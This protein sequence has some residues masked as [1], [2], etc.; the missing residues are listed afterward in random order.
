MKLSLLW[1]KD[2]VDFDWSADELADKLT[3][4]GIEVEGI[5]IRG[6]NFDHVVV[7]EIL[8]SNKHPNADKLSVCKV[9]TDGTT[10]R[11]IVCGA[12]NYAVG[13]R[14]PLAL[15]G[16]VLPGGFAIKESKLRGELSQGMMCSAKELGL[17]EDAEGLLI[18]PKDTPMGTPISE[19]FPTDTIFEIEVTPNRPD[20]L[21]HFGVARELLALGAR[22][23]RS[24][25]INVV[26]SA[27]P[28]GNHLKIENSVQIDCPLYI[29]RVAH[30]AKVGPSPEWMRRRLEAIGV[31]PI[32]NIVDITNFVLH[33]LGQP[34][35]AFDAAKLKGG[36]VKIRHARPGEKIKAL[37]GKDYE[38]DE[39]TLVI[40]DQESPT[41]IAG[42]M[43][44]ELTGVDSSTTQIVLES[45][46]FAPAK[47]RRTSRHLGLGSD[48]SYRFERGVDSEG[49]DLASRR[50]AALLAQ[51]A[52]AT[53]LNGRIE[54]RS[55]TLVPARSIPLRLSRVRKLL[56]VDVAPEK[57]EGI[58][59]TLHLTVSE[60]TAPET[61]TVTV[62]SFRRDLLGEIDLIEEISRIHGL[63]DIPGRVSA[64]VP[65]V[66]LADR[67]T[68]RLDKLRSL[69]NGAGLSEIL[70]HKLVDEKIEALNHA[71]GGL[72]AV[73][74]LNPL[75]VDQDTLRSS[76]IGNL[77]QTL[78]FNVSRQNHSLAL[79][80]TGKVFL[81]FE[82]KLHERLHLSLGLCGMKSA[83]SWDH[84]E[85]TFS[86]Y[87]LKGVVELLGAE[88]GLSPLEFR[89][90]HLSASQQRVFELAAE[91]HGPHKSRLGFL[92]IPSY[93]TR[94]S[95]GLPDATFVAELDLSAFIAPANESRPQ[96]TPPPR[97]PASTRDTALVVDRGVTHAQIAR[98]FQKNAPDLLEK[99][100]LFDIFM[101]DSGSK[102]P[103]DKKSMAY[104]LTYRSLDKTLNDQEI[105]QAHDTLRKK[106]AGEVG[107]GFRE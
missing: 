7:A 1:L 81:E 83:K 91:I 71:A 100:E 90:L 63:D 94:K 3:V 105:N 61:W 51:I 103:A 37:D 65:D 49:V 74:L 86:F 52:G 93:E 2:Y 78:Q 30:G 34:L 107:A 14:V 106:V 24:P 70:T 57:V 28:V 9:T 27:E 44:G 32:N 85:E 4:A 43:G 58:L 41:A 38:L 82:D 69:L 89:K 10:T 72:A 66:S 8:E 19:V 47:I 53:V 5:E 25:E 76:L 104:S 95:H 73:K 40:A 12:K 62:P 88:F 26:E 16:A 23:L 33:E 92:G 80:E 21:S 68:A 39:N 48:S 54:L 36:V 102:L 67:A 50:A 60:G 79:F 59:R 18:L 56:G 55:E 29:G 77:L 35:H 84:P 64:T 31:R 46:L 75:S 13:D 11:Q 98:A 15:P 45:A 6:T 99:I 97:F 17:A 87:D 101:D 42:V 22:N 96:A 20:L